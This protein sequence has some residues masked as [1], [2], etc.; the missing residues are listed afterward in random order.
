M[1]TSGK[2]QEPRPKGPTGG[3]SGDLGRELNHSL[4]TA[5]QCPGFG[6][7]LGA[8]HLLLQGR[9]V[10]QR[11]VHSGHPNPCQLTPHHHHHHHPQ[12]QHHHHHT[13]KKLD[14]F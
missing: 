5:P 8:S 7:E 11:G 4:P 3:P 9:V 1:E 13:Q 10:S 14:T 2:A 6:G 12:H